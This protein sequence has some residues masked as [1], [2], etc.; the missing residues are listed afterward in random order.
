[1][2][3]QKYYEEYDTWSE[4]MQGRVRRPILHRGPVSIHHCRKH[5]GI[6][7]GFI[8]NSQAMIDFAGLF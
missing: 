2:V 4:R 6:N 1:M 7:A 8:A 3:V 5:G